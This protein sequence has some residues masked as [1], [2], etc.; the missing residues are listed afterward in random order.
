[1]DRYSR[2]PRRDAVKVEK[3]EGCKTEVKENI[4][5]RKRLAPREKVQGD[6]KKT[7]KK[8]YGRLRQEI[9]MKT[10][11]CTVQWTSRKR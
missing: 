8:I 11:L 5:R 7:I 6:K 3:F 9:G 10:C 1:M 2:E 4:E